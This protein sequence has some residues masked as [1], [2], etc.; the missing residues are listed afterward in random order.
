M[1]GLKVIGR[2][3]IVCGANC[4]ELGPVTNSKT[5]PAID[6]GIVCRSTGNYGSTEYDVMHGDE[7]IEFIVCDKCLVEK[8]KDIQRI[9]FKDDGTI[10]VRESFDSYDRRL[11]SL[12]KIRRTNGE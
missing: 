4:E 11:K 12:A 5:I 2:K 6:S 10:A 1:T 9:S 3:C 7:L 8:G